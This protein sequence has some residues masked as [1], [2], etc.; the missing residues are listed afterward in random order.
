VLD[1]SATE[2]RAG[3]EGAREGVWARSELSTESGSITEVEA[4]SKDKAAVWISSRG[5]AVARG[6]S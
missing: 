5:L 6:T 4:E 3:L 1:E 2:L